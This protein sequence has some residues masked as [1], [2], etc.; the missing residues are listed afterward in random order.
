MLRHVCSVDDD[1]C[2][3]CIE[4]DIDRALVALLSSF[5]DRDENAINEALDLALVLCARPA[6]PPSLP[7][8]R[9]AAAREADAFR[10]GLV[11]CGA[12]PPLLRVLQGVFDDLCAKDVPG[13]AR[14]RPPPLRRCVSESLPS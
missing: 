13:P 12:L 4:L 2:S 10:A 7:A 1:S 9:S 3:E 11:R 8:Y 6:A 14:R 5:T